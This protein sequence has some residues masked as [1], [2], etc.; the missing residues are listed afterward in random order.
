MSNLI[1]AV[2]TLSDDATITGSAVDAAGPLVNV[3][4]DQPTDIARFASVTPYM[5]I[6]LGVVT[7][8]NLIALLFT[9]GQQ[10]DTWRI[11]TADTQA[12]LTSGPDYDSGSVDFS[13]WDTAA[14][15]RHGFAWRSAGWSNR[16]IRIDIDSTGNVDGV[17]DIGRLFVANAYQPS[18]NASYGIS[19]GF[20]DVSPRDRTQYGNTIANR[21][22][23]IPTLAFDIKLDDEEEFYA[24]TY[25]LQQAR[26]G[27]R[28]LLIIVDP[29]HATRAH[30]K[31][32]Y[33]LLAP[34][35]RT[36]NETYRIFTQRFELEGMI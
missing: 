5:V 18:R 17:F 19:Y 2:P 27:S 35:V 1:I 30:D 28:P 34:T 21:Q 14:D 7:T 26:G 8:F 3:Q 25:Q 36:T 24:N 4:R 20:I 10:T 13:P 32:Y 9:N 23:I 11:R 29:D 6:D 33:G 12:E 31:L 22:G 15:R 16:W